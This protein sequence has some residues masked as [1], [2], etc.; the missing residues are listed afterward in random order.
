MNKHVLAALVSSAALSATLLAP[1]AAH[2]VIGDV[3]GG[4]DG[5]GGGVGGGGGTSTPSNDINKHFSWE[6]AWG[7]TSWGAGIYAGGGVTALYVAQCHFD[8]AYC[9][10]AGCRMPTHGPD[11]GR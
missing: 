9:R 10:F 3:G 5:G 1:T 2:A 11:C 7:N 4:D 6:Q 8:A